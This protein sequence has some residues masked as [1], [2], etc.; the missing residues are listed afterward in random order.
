MQNLLVAVVVSVATRSAS[1]CLVQTSS[2]KMVFLN[3]VFHEWHVCPGYFPKFGH[4]RDLPRHAS[5]SLGAV[6]AK[7]P[8]NYNVLCRRI[9]AAKQFSLII[10]G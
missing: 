6:I 5:F 1:K 2:E 7:L 10:V 4:M 3:D 8:N 9:A